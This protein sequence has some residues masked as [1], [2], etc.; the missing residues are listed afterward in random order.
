MSRA[1]VYADAHAAA[2]ANK[3]Q[4]TASAPEPFVGPNG[5]AEVTSTG[6]LHLRQT[7]TGDFEISAPAALAFA[8]WINSTFG[9]P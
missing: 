9:E 6:W 8:A 3:A 5:T 4:V 7:T 2:D 1:S